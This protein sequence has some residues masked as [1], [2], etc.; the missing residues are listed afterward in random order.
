MTRKLLRN[1][2]F[3]PD[4]FGGPDD[5]QGKWQRTPVMG[6]FCHFV[7]QMVPRAEPGRECARR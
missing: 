6:V 1:T 7:L 4:G 5:D 3:W 2:F